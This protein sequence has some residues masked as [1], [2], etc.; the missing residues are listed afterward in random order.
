MVKSRFKRHGSK[1]NS[2]KTVD[3][4]SAF[5]LHEIDNS[6]E[7]DEAISKSELKRQMTYL[8][9]MGEA[10]LTLSNKAFEDLQLSPTLVEALRTAERIKHREGKRRQMQ[11]VG[12]LMRKES[13]E[14][15]NRIKKALDIKQQAKAKNAEQLH[16]VENW[17]DQLL[18]D[19]D[20]AIETLLARYPQADRQW[21]RQII[22]QHQHEM[23][24]QKPPAASRKLFTYL[25]E[26][27]ETNVG[28]QP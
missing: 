24:K 10:L 12:K 25:R 13:P 27:F 28:E 8:Q 17:R 20:S 21:L 9:K 3:A 4:V 5:N 7:D 22:R 11:F 15:I 6:G 2:N 26:L 18:A 1:K 23:A 19:G 14:S 16:V